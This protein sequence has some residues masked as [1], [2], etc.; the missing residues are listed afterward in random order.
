MF[1]P[2]D[3]ILVDEHLPE[4][5][6]LLMKLAE[7]TNLNQVATRK[8]ITINLNKKNCYPHGFYFVTFINFKTFL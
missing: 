8:G 4:M 2:L 6:N 5:N 3:Q 7:L 1:S